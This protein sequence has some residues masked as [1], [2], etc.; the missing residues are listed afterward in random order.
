TITKF[1]TDSRYYLMVRGWLVQK[2]R[3]TD[4]RLQ[5]QNSQSK[6]EVL[7]TEVDALNQGIRAIDLE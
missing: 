5:S 2:V 6:R 4:S 7:V 3:G 1:G